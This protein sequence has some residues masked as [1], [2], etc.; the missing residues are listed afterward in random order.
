ME[1]EILSKDMF[2]RD[3]LPNIEKM[4]DTFFISILDPDEKEPLREDSENY[5]TFW[6]YDLESDIQIYK[7]ITPEQAESIIEF[8]IDNKYKKKFVVHCTAGVSRSGAIGEAVWEL[9][10]G[11]YQELTRKFNSI[12][13]SGRVLM[14]LRYAYERYR[15]EERKKTCASFWLN[16]EN[17]WEDT[18]V[19]IDT[20]IDYLGQGYDEFF[21]IYI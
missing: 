15:E 6:F 4:E 17:M 19:C 8:I 11:S 7:A 18:G 10:G 1:V 12:L 16:P 14:Y 9:F 20:D 13:P 21:K 5:K 3:I 2:V